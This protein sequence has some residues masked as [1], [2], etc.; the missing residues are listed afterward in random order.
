MYPKS[1]SMF[2]EGNDLKSLSGTL[3]IAQ[4]SKMEVR[5]SFFTKIKIMDQILIFVMCP[6]EQ[7]LS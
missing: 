4:C 5:N 6:N 2:Y 3:Y 1:L 7:L